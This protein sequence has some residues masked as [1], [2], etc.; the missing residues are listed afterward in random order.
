MKYRI[1][2]DANFYC[3]SLETNQEIA[4][5]LDRGRQVYLV[6]I[7]GYTHGNQTRFSEIY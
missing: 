5:N 7:E 2:K 3:L 4:Y 1:H 6:Q